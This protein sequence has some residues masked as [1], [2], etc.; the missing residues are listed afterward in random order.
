[1]RSWD[2]PEGPPSR[3]GPR[4]TGGRYAP[5]SAAEITAD[6]L[7]GRV[8]PEVFGELVPLPAPDTRHPMFLS[9]W[10][11]LV[12]WFKATFYVERIGG[13][14]TIAIGPLVLSWGETWWRRARRRARTMLILP[15]AGLSLR[16][17]IEWQRRR[18]LRGE[19]RL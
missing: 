15:P 12:A 18:Y 1:M 10:D 6:L 5:E 4:L 9:G 2:A 19:R 14:L 3:H 16:D 7:A 17:T 11:I 13:V 8:V